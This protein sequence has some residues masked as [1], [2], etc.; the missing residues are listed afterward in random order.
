MQ[1]WGVVVAD[2][3]PDG[4]AGTAGIKPEDIVLSLED[5][6]MLTLTQF[7]AGFYLHP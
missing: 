6:P 7:A 4:P 1:D 5:H 2:I 3:A